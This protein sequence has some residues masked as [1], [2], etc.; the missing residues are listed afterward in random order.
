MTLVTEFQVLAS[1]IVFRN[2]EYATHSLARSPTA[3]HDNSFF[4][5]FLIPKFHFNV[6]VV[7]SNNPIF[8]R[9]MLQVRKLLLKYAVS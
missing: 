7:V 6:P 5:P 3:K 9:G 1:F 4:S 2:Y 8:E